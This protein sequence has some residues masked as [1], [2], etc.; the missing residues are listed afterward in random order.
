MSQET[1]ILSDAVKA[2]IDHWLKKFPQDQR[3]SA[4]IP[5]LHILQDEQNWLSTPMMDAVAAYLGVT[6]MEVYEVASFYSMFDLE[7][8]GRHKIKLC[9]S[10]SCDLCGAH[11]IG[12]HLKQKLGVDYGETTTDG[13]FTLQ[14]VE[15]LGACRGGPVKLLDKVYYEHL[16]T[17]EVDEILDRCE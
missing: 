8:M 9:G 2:K 6:S 4:L 10:I 11:K 12:N 1:F 5:A 3:R 13:K 16:T 7:P 15:C 17:K 14:E